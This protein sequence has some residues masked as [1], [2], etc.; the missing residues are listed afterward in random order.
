MRTFNGKNSK[1]NIIAVK[2]IEE[3]ILE[4]ELLKKGI[5]I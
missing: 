3:H 5:E 2:S 4:Q 1:I